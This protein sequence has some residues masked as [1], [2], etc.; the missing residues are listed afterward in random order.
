MYGRAHLDVDLDVLAGQR[1]RHLAADPLE[2]VVLGVGHGA[3]VGPPRGAVVGV[4]RDEAHRRRLVEAGRRRTASCRRRCRATRPSARCSGGSRRQRVVELVDVGAA[5]DPAAEHG[6]VAV[7]RGDRH[8]L[9]D[10]G[11]READD[12]PGG[13]GPG[14]PAS[15]G[16]P[17]LG[18][19]G[20]RV[21]G[22]PG[23]PPEGEPGERGAEHEGPVA[24]TAA[25]RAGSRRPGPAA[26]ARPG[27]GCVGCGRRARPTAPGAEVAERVRAAP[28][29]TRRGR[30]AGSWSAAARSR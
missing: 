7:E 10:D 9:G 8:D 27:P 1:R 4:E 17:D 19:A 29:P 12:Q 20:G 30:A 14:E 26:A 5:A 21:G 28:S 13:H 23:R 18:A 24:R 11:D 16:V 15:P 2:Q 22:S 25:G 6:P 3:V